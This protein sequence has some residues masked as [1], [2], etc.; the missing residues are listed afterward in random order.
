MLELRDPQLELVP[1]VA[2][3]EAELA[4]EVLQRRFVPSP[5]RSASPRQR[6][7]R[8][9]SSERSLVEARPEQ[10]RERVALE[11]VLAG[12]PMRPR[13]AALAAPLALRGVVVAV[14]VDAARP[15]S[16]GVSGRRLVGGSRLGLP[17]AGRCDSTPSV[18]R[19]VACAARTRARAPSRA[20][21]SGAAMKIDE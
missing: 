1:L 8:S 19:L 13:L 4:R 20:S 15:T 17:A 7:P 14:A 2:R 12:P 5:T 18:D 21:A 10:R 3:H 9:S 11:V 16:T 6:E